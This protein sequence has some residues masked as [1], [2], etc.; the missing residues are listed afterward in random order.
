MNVARAGIVGV[1]HEQVHVAN[2]RRLVREIAN[3]RREIV[4]VATELVLGHEL[5]RALAGGR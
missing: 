1:A 5:D 3:V 4:I 2:D